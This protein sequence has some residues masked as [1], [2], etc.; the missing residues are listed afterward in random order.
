M[1]ATP[2]SGPAAHV[3][4]ASA[5]RAN[6]E[7]ALFVSAS[8]GDS[9]T[10]RDSTACS[11]SAVSPDWL[12]AKDNV[13]GWGISSAA[14]LPTLHVTGMP[15]RRRTR[16]PIT[17]PGIQRRAASDHMQ[18]LEGQQPKPGPQ[19][20]VRDSVAEFI[21]HPCHR[22]GLFVDLLGRV[23]GIT[24]QV[25]ISTAPGAAGRH[26]RHSDGSA[27]APAA[28]AGQFDDVTVL[29]NPELVDPVS[30]RGDVTRREVALGGVRDQQRRT[31]SGD[32][33]PAGAL[34]Q[35]S[36][37][38]GALCSGERDLYG[39]E[40]IP[41]ALP[42]IFDQVTQ[43]LTVHRCGEPVT[44]PG[45]RIP[46]TD[47]I[48]DYSVV[49]QADLSGAVDVRVRVALG[50]RPVGRPPG[51]TDPDAIELGAGPLAHQPIECPD[52][53]DRS[54]P[55]D[56]AGAGLHR[57]THGV[58]AA[59]FESTKRDAKVIDRR[60]MCSARDDAAHHRVSRSEIAVKKSA[61]GDDNDARADCDAI[62]AS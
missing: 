27:V 20:P 1:A 53:S 46:Q 26:R 38:P 3:T 9:A 7:C 33:D 34:F 35:H 47:C 54:Q 57:N 58:I 15:P 14:S 44:R 30:D 56:V 2:I 10:A 45:Q 48:F 22:F 52:P 37:T 41:A 39:L 51:V 23:V 42:F 24:V 28:T 16:L 40:K 11:T 13:P 21:E 49:H 6:V 55:H 12:I 5:R 50:H 8:S 43:H 59:I 17:C 32:H 4:T 31:V 19:R 60:P 29:E 36:Q 18:T 25:R 62:G 61:G